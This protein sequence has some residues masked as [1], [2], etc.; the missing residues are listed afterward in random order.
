MT[1]S[2]AGEARQLRSAKAA[3]ARRR[4]CIDRER[5]PSH[6]GGRIGRAPWRST[7]LCRVEPLTLTVRSNFGFVVIEVADPI[8]DPP[9][10]REPV[11]D[12]DLMAGG[13]GLRLVGLLTDSW[14]YYPSWN[15][16]TVWACFSRY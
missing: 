2:T 8:T 9:T 5:G 4:P 6:E 16:K 11:L 3:V 1:P 13:W 14:G 12:G 10:L 7:R 15:G